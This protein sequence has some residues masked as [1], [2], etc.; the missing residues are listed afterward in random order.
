MK[1]FLLGAGPDPG[2]VLAYLRGM[3]WH[4]IVWAAAWSMVFDKRS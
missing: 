4:D 2:E 1:L 3:E